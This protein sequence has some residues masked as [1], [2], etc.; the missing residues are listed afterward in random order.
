MTVAPPTFTGKMRCLNCPQRPVF[1]S[2]A[3]LDEHWRLTHTVPQEHTAL[4]LLGPTVHPMIL[5]LA[6]TLATNTIKLTEQ[7]LE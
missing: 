6:P 7:V 1:Y 2:Q 5:A 4:E 3:A